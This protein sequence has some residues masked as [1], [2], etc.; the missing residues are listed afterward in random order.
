[1]SSPKMI[2]VLTEKLAQSATVCAC[3]LIA[4]VGAGCLS[5]RPSVDSAAALV[6][7]QRSTVLPSAIRHCSQLPPYRLRQCRVVVMPCT[8]QTVQIPSRSS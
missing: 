3:S 8:W 4:A 5:C 7:R 1:M 2:C 6:R